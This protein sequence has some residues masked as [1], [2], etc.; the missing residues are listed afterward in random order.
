[1]TMYPTSQNFGAYNIRL[2]I[3]AVKQALTLLD[4]PLTPH[5]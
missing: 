4:H 3:Q 5:T 1:M 2:S